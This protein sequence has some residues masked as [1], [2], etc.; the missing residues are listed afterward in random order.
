MF[1]GYFIPE[2]PEGQSRF[3]CCSWSESKSEKN[4]SLISAID[5][6]K[7]KGMPRNKSGTSF[8]D[9]GWTQQRQKMS[10]DFIFFMYIIF[11]TLS[12]IHYTYI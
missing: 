10:E 5:E 9:G 6:A 7:T 12:H 1:V 11:C 4:N 2:K 8:Q 3:L